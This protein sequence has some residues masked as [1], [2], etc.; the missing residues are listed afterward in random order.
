FVVLISITLYFYP[1]LKSYLGDIPN[2]YIEFSS[3]KLTVWPLNPVYLT[4]TFV[5]SLVF[6]CTSAV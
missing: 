3:F 4:L 1:F 2:L 6:G 5:L